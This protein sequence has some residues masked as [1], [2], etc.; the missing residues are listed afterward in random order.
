M[1]R[2]SLSLSRLGL[3]FK[4]SRQVVETAAGADLRIKSLKGEVGGEGGQGGLRLNETFR[5]GC[6]NWMCNKLFN[7][8]THFGQSIG[9][10]GWVQARQIIGNYNSLVSKNFTIS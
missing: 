3:F 7:A 2:V 1:E 9:T 8:L 4:V 10:A 5:Q 6:S